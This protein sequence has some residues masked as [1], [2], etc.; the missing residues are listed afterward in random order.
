[1][2]KKIWQRKPHWIR[3]GSNLGPP[4]DDSEIPRP[5]TWDVYK[6]FVNNGMKLPT[7]Q[8]VRRIFFHQQDFFVV[9]SQSWCFH[10]YIYITPCFGLTWNIT[11]V[12]VFFSYISFIK[13]PSF[14]SIFSSRVPKWF[15]CFSLEFQI[16]Q[17]Q[18]IALFFLACG[19]CLT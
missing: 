3:Q 17:P 15:P 2:S 13:R 4:V 8:P 19:D 10:I 1:M 14:S 18:T 12:T 6:T 9:I 5:T 16:P 11:H 7:Y